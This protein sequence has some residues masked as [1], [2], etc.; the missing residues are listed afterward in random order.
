MTGRIYVIRRKLDKRENRMRSVL[1]GLLL[2]TLSA[3][4]GTAVAQQVD[5]VKAVEFGTSFPTAVLTNLNAAASG[6]ATVDLNAVIGKRPVVFYY[7]IPGNARADAMLTNIESMLP[8]LGETADIAVYAVTF[9]V[10]GRGVEIIQARAKELK[11][12]LPVLEDK[13]FRIGQQLRV[14]SVPFTAI[15]DKEGKLQMSNGAS[16]TQEIEYKFTVASAIER[17]ART[18]KVGSYGYLS[19]Y[20]PVTELV[21]KKCPDFKAPL[22]STSVEQSWYSMLKKDHVNVLIFWSVDCPHCRKSLPEINTWLKQNHAGFNVISAARVD[23]ETSKTKTK[24]FCDYNEFVFPTLMDKDLAIASLY[25]VTSTPTILV[26]RPDG[27]VDSV[28]LS[29]LKDFG[30]AME[31]KKKELLGG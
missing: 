4:T 19:R 22:L 9:P 6:P 18:G 13:G 11:L 25:Q 7:W 17:V 29:T 23:N 27:V 8:E 24:E 3:T 5:K 21:G 1:L 30:Q 28:V 10:E 14:Q 2:I 16:L 20:Y 26:I 31:K 15:L 12:S